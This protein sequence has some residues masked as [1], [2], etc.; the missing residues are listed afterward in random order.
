MFRIITLAS[1]S[2]H[3]SSVT[4]A[5]ITLLCFMY[6]SEYGHMTH[7]TMP[8]LIL[9]S[10]PLQKKDVVFIDLWVARFHQGHGDARR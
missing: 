5:F 3:F 10:S 8:L 4:R 1:T 9:S 7:P 6:M 2:L